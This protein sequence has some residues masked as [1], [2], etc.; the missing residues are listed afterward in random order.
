MIYEIRCGRRDGTLACLI[1]IARASDAAA[2]ALAQSIAAPTHDRIEVWRD[3]HCVH[4]GL[5][6]RTEAGTA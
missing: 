1:L 3:E 4:Q 6:D 2:V 5:L